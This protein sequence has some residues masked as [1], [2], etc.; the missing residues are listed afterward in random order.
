MAVKKREWSSILLPADYKQT[1]YA[2]VASYKFGKEAGDYAG[3]YLYHPKSLISFVPNYQSKELQEPLAADKIIFKSSA[4]LTLKKGKQEIKIGADEFIDKFCGLIESYIL[5]RH[6]D[7]INGAFLSKKEERVEK[8]QQAEESLLVEDKFSDVKNILDGSFV[9][10]FYENEKKTVLQSEINGKFIVVGDNNILSED[11]EIF[12]SEDEKKSLLNKISAD[13]E[14]FYNNVDD[15]IMGLVSGSAGKTMLKLSEDE[16][17]NVKRL[18]QIKF[19]ETPREYQDSLPTLEEFTKSYY[20]TNVLEKGWAKY[21]SYINEKEY[22]KN[23]PYPLRNNS[24]FICWK[25]EYYDSNGN[26]RVKPAKMPYNPRTGHKAMTNIAGTWSDFKTACSA[27]DT[28]G[29]NG[30]GVVFTKGLIGIDLDNCIDDGKIT[31]MAK[32]VIERLNS[33]TEYSPSGTGVHIL[34]FGMLP[35]AAL[36][37]DSIGFEMYS[38]EKGRF[39]TLTGKPYENT[40]IKMQGEKVNQPRIDEVYNEFAAKRVVASIGGNERQPVKVPLNAPTEEKFSDK[41]LISRI[42]KSTKMSTKFTL[43]CQNK[44]PM[45]WDSSIKKYTSEK[46]PF[47]YRQDGTLDISNL[48]NSFAKILVFY[49]ATPM[50]IDRIYRAQ[51][52]ENKVEGVTI[53]G[54]CL[55]REKWDKPINSTTS[56]GQYVINGAFAHVSAVYNENFRSNK[57]GTN[58]NGSSNKNINE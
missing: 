22:E 12:L 1:E 56:Y 58:S 21:K 11:F 38:Y 48:D 30:L 54:A 35:G 26:P 4:T 55:A 3:F 42:M 23:T 52:V 33:Y 10:G 53:S 49:G 43:L 28:L 27:V 24:N 40:F 6:S 7:L 39:F 57:G 32:S 17:S 15:A 46:D 14:I 8:K 18:Y 20:E 51:S 45:V 29:M 5:N 2:Q 25:F 41:E 16:Q 47:F 9:E 36:K 44:A 19:S 37:M 34:A 50:Q 31:D 13:E